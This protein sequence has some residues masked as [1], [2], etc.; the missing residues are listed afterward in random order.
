M[1]S[2]TIS[3]FYVMTGPRG[4]TK[5][6]SS[7][8]MFDNCLVFKTSDQVKDGTWEIKHET[9]NGLTIVDCPG[10]GYDG[11]ETG[12]QGVERSFGTLELYRSFVRERNFFEGKEVTAF[13]FCIKFVENVPD[14]TFQKA[15]E[16][17]YDVFGEMGVRSMFFLVVQA[18]V[19]MPAGEFANILHETSAYKFLRQK[20]NKDIPFCLWRNE[21]LPYGDQ[22][23]NFQSCVSQI[24]R[25]K[26]SAERF[27][28]L[29][30]RIDLRIQINRERE[31]LAT[32]KA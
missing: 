27:E 24:D 30:A 26:F 7:N 15:V 9:R 2:D 16:D 11:I 1:P 17:F 3:G 29:T 4:C 6:T 19:Q 10:F 25:F 20:T 31:A 22:R 23:A 12:N 18:G 32:A 28:V 8:T 5:S 13:V 14:A 21:P